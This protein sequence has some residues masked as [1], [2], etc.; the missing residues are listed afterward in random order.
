V[1]RIS[2]R[3]PALVPHTR[4][5][6]IDLNPNLKS[7]WV[8]EQLLHIPAATAEWESIFIVLA[9]NAVFP[10]VLALSITWAFDLMT[11][12]GTV[13]KVGTFRTLAP[14]PAHALML[15]CSNLFKR[16][17]G[18]NLWWSASRREVGASTSS[19]FAGL[20]R[21]VPCG[22]TFSHSCFS[23]LELTRHLRRRSQHLQRPAPLL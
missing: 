16:T 2:V 6:L 11:L 19:S 17:R 14:D 8:Y 3:W 21:T 1:S 5:G 18:P 7:Y 20:G 23:P 12:D 13:A 4:A 10:L 22:Y 9:S 15:P